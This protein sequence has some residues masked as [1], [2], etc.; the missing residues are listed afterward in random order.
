MRLKKWTEQEIAILRENWNIPLRELLVFLPDRDR[1]QIYWKLGVLGFRRQTFKR[2]NTKDD[3]YIRENYQ[4]KGNFEIGRDLK[5]TAKSITK[6][7][8]IL[9]LKRSDD[10]LKFLKKTN[11]GCFKQGR[12]SEKTVPNGNLRLTYDETSDRSFYDIKID[13]KFVRFSRYLYEKYHNEELKPT[14][15]IFHL[16][17]DGMNVLK[18]NLVKITRSELLEKNNMTDV[19]FVKRIFR[20]TDPEMIKEIIDNHPEMIEVKRKIITINK[21]INGRNRKINGIAD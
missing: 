5:R 9:G 16:D 11:R 13:G 20:V 4:K 2:Y 17:G 21:K 8:I 14:D 7:M 18:E 1:K 19:A 3:I 12:V 10:E 6:R 15:I